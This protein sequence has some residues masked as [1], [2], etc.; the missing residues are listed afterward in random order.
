MRMRNNLHHK[1]LWVE[2]IMVV[3]DHASSSGQNTTEHGYPEKHGT[4]RRNLKVHDE[5]GIGDGGENEHSGEGARDE[6]D[7][8]STIVRDGYVEGG[9]DVPHDELHLLVREL[10]DVAGRDRIALV[11]PALEEVR[12]FVEL[13]ELPLRVEC[14]LPS[15]NRRWVFVVLLQNEPSAMRMSGDVIH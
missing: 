5:V 3:W 1:L 15:S 2:H 11:Q 9:W 6:G 8:S 7:E 10:A 4:V 13:A 12:Q 14:I